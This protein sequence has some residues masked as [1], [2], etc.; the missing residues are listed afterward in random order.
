MSVAGGDDLRRPTSRYTD[1]VRSSGPALSQQRVLRGLAVGFSLVV[2]LLVVAVYVGYQ[3]SRAIHDNAHELVREHLLTSERGARLELLIEERSQELLDDLELVLGLCLVMAI[4]SAVVAIWTTQRAFERLAW[5]ADELSRVSWQMLQ[6]QEM[7][8]RRFSHEM[9]DELGQTLTG[10]RGMLKQLT[11]AAFE[12]RR[13][14]CVG[15]LDQALTGVRELSQLLRPVIL[16]DFGLDAGLRWLAAGFAERTGIPV[17]Y[18]SDF[19]GRLQDED[20]THLFRIAQEG[21]T[22]IARHAKATSASVTLH[23]TG[24]EIALTIEDDGRGLIGANPG[25]PSLGMVGMRA[26]ARHIGG[27]LDVISKPEGGV[28]LSVR[29]PARPA[30]DDNDNDEE[31]AHPAG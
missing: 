19:E 11:P 6:D 15:I 20:E 2:I 26:R 14:E 7:T 12:Q 24:S 25:R 17:H 1:A 13:Q 21:L 10:L 18:E 9:H 8:A 28:R 23:L 5:H 16:D 31:D 30:G 3:G 29:A 27:D 4:T 22:N